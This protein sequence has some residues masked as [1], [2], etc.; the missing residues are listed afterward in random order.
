MAPGQDSELLTL[1]PESP[2]HGGSVVAREAD[3]RVVFVHYALPGETVSARPRGKRG[4]AAFA[5]TA[6]VLLAS[7]DRVEAAC[8]YF[9]ECGGCHWQHARYAM[10][11]AFKR[12][13]VEDIWS[14]AGLRLPPDT[15]VL[16]MEDPWRYRIR[17]EFEG[18]NGSGG[19]EFGFHRLRSHSVIP[20]RTCPIHHERIEA[21]LGAFRQAVRDLGLRTLKSILLT[22][23]PEGPG[24]LWQARLDGRRPGNVLSELGQRAAELLP[25]AVLLDDSMDLR[26]WGLQFRVRSDTFVQANHRQMPLLYR[27]ALDML[28]AGPGDRVLDLYSGIGT[29]SLAAARECGGVT[30]V[31][32]NPRAVSLARLAARINGTDRVQ[33]LTGRVEDAL[34]QVRVGEHEALIA[35]PPRAGF[36]QAAL[37]EV[38]RLG[39]ARIAYISCEPSTQA[40]DVALLVSAGYRVRRAAIVDM[41]P[42]T[43]HIES[44]VLLERAA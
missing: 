11:L 7:P 10:Q 14:R 37:A 15:P 38:L 1:R 24:L 21:G 30:A 19:F 4:G 27:S 34:R 33:F 18:I 12:R 35:D 3:G 42:Q 6:Q 29:I 28:A 44:V 17:G 5:S 40:R 31:E 25:G 16:G 8:P 2:A 26:L 9:G 41:F 32:E 22:A 20:I 13:V 36:E 43:Y 39:P 23:E